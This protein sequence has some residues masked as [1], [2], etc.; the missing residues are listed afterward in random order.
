MCLWYGNAGAPAYMSLSA[1]PGNPPYSRRLRRGASHHSCGCCTL[2]SFCRPAPNN[3]QKVAVESSASPRLACLVAAPHLQVAELQVP[4]VLMHM[5]GTP[6][7]MQSKQHTAYTDVCAE[8]AAALQAQG[9]LAGRVG[10]RLR[11][12][13]LR[14]AALGW[15]C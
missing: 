11:A 14:C 2:R 8:V 10:G 13:P 4:Y 5:R 6:Q 7:T 15:E 12:R 1:A 9:A 3:P